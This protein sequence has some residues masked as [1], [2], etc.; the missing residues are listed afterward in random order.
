MKVTISTP[1]LKETLGISQS[2]LGT[3]SDITS[4][5]VFV[6]E[7]SGASVLS[8]SPPRI[9][10]KIPLSGATIQDSSS[11]SLD[12][13]RILKAISATSG[14]LEITHSEEEDEQGEVSIKSKN[15]SLTLSSLDPEAFPSWMEKLDEA[16]K[17]KDISSSVLYDT[18]NS[19]KGYVSQDDNR[20]PELAMLVIQESGDA[21]A[22]DGFALSVARHEEFKGL[23]IKLHHKDL[24]PLMKFLKAYEGNVIEVLKGGS[25]TF[26]RAEDGAVFG[27]MD[28][29]HTFPAM[30]TQYAEAFDWTP[31]RVWRV[32][33]N[34]IMTGINF[35][36]AGADATDLR[37]TFSHAE[38][39]MGAP[40]LE[41]K[42]NSG[43]GTLS[44]TLEVPEFNVENAEDITDPGDLMYHSRLNTQAEGDDIPEFKFNYLNMKR[45]IET[46]GD[47]VV[48]GCNQE[49]NKGYMVFKGAS[50]AGVQTVAVIGWMM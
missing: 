5:F 49:G 1:D 15:G 33:K 29:P 21:F 32:S 40:C 27:T 20:R 9:F 43:K 44:Y 26:Y 18:L 36:S 11:F 14:V 46:M 30:M 45:A 7:G 17:V 48:I 37:V 23:D 8:C 31:R 22:C 34:S 6:R 38:G 35:L 39:D 50:T 4:H 42:P 28:L 2:T 41:M 16:E 25:A 47:N 12:G 13:K 24:A 19:L 3:S 10:S